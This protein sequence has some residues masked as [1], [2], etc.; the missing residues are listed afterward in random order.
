M[1]FR[2]L[3]KYHGNN[4]EVLQQAPCEI[5][6]YLIKVVWMAQWERE[7]AG[8]WVEFTKEDGEKLED[9]YQKKQQTKKVCVS[10]SHIYN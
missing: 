7:D 2:F 5:S 9:G 8:G 6:V 10:T 1:Y 3:L 4:F